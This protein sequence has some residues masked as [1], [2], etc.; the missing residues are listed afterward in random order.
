MIAL[1]DAGKVTSFALT[2]DEAGCRKL[3]RALPALLGVKVFNRPKTVFS[4]SKKPRRKI[5]SR[6]PRDPYSRCACRH[7]GLKHAGN[8]CELCACTKFRRRVRPVRG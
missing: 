5:R 2:A 7:L 8:R 1:D 3:E 6:F 4:Q